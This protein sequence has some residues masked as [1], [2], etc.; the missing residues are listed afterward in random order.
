MID[1]LKYTRKLEE[2]GFEREQAEIFVRGQVSMIS[3]N[4]TTKADLEK[5]ESNINSSVLTLRSEMKEMATQ[6][7]SEMKEVATELRS[8]MKEKFAKMET[9]FVIKISVIMGIQLTTLATIAKF[10]F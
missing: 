10:F 1:V 7:R 6:L 9:S 4:V 8:E 5:V 3:D 2:A